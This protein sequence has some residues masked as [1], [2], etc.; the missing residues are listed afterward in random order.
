MRDGQILEIQKQEAKRLAMVYR[1]LQFVD[2]RISAYEKV[3]SSTWNKL[4]AMLNHAWLIREVEKQQLEMLKAHDDVIREKAEKVKEEKVKT[5]LTI[6]GAN[7]ISKLGIVLIAGLFA[8]GCVSAKKFR[9]MEADMAHNQLQTFVA[10]EECRKAYKVQSN[11]L[12]AKTER[13]KRFNQLDEQGNLRK[14]NIFKGDVD[15]E[16]WDGPDGSEPWLK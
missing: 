15:P 9:K 10:L 1:Q 16:G 12:R 4:K 6:V 5:K 7:G 11:E 14:L 13:L 8:S 3:L 2:T